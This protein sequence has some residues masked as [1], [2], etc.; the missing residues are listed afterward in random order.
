MGTNYYLHKN[1][2]PHCGKSDTEKHIGK[3]SAGWCFSLHIYPEDGIN[4]LPDWEKLF[5]ETGSVIK[6]EYGEELTSAEMVDMIRNR[7]RPQKW[8][9]APQGYESWDQFHS[10][11]DSQNGPMG[12]IRHRVG[13]FCRSNGEGTWDCIEGDF[14]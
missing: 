11:N 6:N 12:M 14:S 5:F 8:D 3:S 9:K 2:C 1:V 10:Q 13:M 7:S 4:D